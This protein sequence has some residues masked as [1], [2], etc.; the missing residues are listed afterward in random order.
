[1]PDEWQDEPSPSPVQQHQQVGGEHH[2]TVVERR[3]RRR[4]R[5]LMRRVR[6]F[7]MW[8]SGGYL[9]WWLHWE[10]IQLYLCASV[11]WLVYTSLEGDK[12]PR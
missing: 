10:S 9:V 3:H 7:I 4:R 6:R 8:L 12:K 2:E 11:L 5:R 1:M